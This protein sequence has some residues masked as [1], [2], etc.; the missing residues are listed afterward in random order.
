MYYY[1]FYYWMY[2]RPVAIIIGK[3]TERNYKVFN[4]GCRRGS[5][6][7]FAIYT[8][9]H[10]NTVVCSKCSLVSKSLKRICGY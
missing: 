1:S 3:A 7:N 2:E 8:V 10:H 6:N 5:M 9:H 4:I